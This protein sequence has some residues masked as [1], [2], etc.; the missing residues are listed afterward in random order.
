MSLNNDELSL[1]QIDST[2]GGAIKSNGTI[3]PKPKSGYFK[4]LASSI[5]SQQIS[6]KAAASIFERFEKMTKLSPELTISLSPEQSK[7][8][9]LSG[10][11]TRYLIDLAHHF[12]NDSNVFSHLD[13]L[14]DDEVIHELTKVK[15]IGIWTAQMFLI[16][17]LRRPDI[18]APDDRGLQIAV[19]KLYK[20]SYTRS[21]LN[22]FS[23]RWS[24]YRST[25]C[26]HL[27]RTL[28]S[29]PT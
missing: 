11:K 20:K 5:I 28:D 18:F 7:T 19:E 21:E 27:W 16:F 23:A 3:T 12:V 4:A 26:L 14:N 8:I 10:Q 9:G 15:G 24:P 17:T 25:A 22:N 1:I 13:T 2:L 6:V 29:E